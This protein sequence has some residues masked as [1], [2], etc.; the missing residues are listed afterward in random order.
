MDILKKVWSW[1]WRQSVFNKIVIVGLFAAF[2]P[3]VLPTVVAWF[4]PTMIK[5]G[6]AFYTYERASQPQ[7]MNTLY[8][9]EKR[10]LVSSCSIHRTEQSVLSGRAT[11][12]DSQAWVVI[13]LLLENTSDRAITNLRV[14]VR[15]P[16]INPATRIA[17]APNLGA[18]GNR[19]ASSGTRPL[20]LISMG[21]LPAESS[22]VV[23]LKTPI[24][25]DMRDFIYVKKRTVTI[26]VPYVSADQF[27]QYP[28]IVSRTNAVKILN[29]EGVLRTNDE[30]ASDEQIQVSM[31]SS[32]EPVVKEGGRTYELL[33]KAKACSEAEAGVW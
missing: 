9:F 17:T 4:R 11:A 33:P 20:Y 29:R 8:F 26:Q 12:P 6:V 24:D 16:A 3:F 1:F 27:R 2:V 21:T 18:V 23:S 22:A 31:L 30:F 5:V 32:D 25:D 7:G 19:E 10:N 15:S 13:K 28:P 14:G